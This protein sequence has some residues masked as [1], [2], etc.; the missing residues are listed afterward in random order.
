MERVETMILY[1]KELLNEAKDLFGKVKTNNEELATIITQCGI[2]QEVL[3]LIIN[4]NMTNITYSEYLLSLIK[5]HASIEWFKLIDVYRDNQIVLEEINDAFNDHVPVEVVKSYLAETEN[6]EEMM[7]KRYKWLKDNSKN[8]ESTDKATDKK[9]NVSR[10]IN[11]GSDSSENN[12]VDAVEKNESESSSFKKNET[13]MTISTSQ[14][15]AS[16]SDKP[17]ISKFIEAFLGVDINEDDHAASDDVL[18][19]EV[20]ANLTEINNTNKKRNLEILDLKKAAR[21]YQ[22][23]AA[24]AEIKNAELREEN[25]QLKNEL[26][27]VQKKLDAYMKRDELVSLQLSELNKIQKPN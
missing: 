11:S 16:E 27:E 5:K 20:L 13:S 8:E 1:E 17:A 10:E 21:M 2:E 14:E 9:N 6:P 19:Q 3:Q 4:N 24:S 7:D 22:A 12:A 26:A 18:F 23:N 15:A 25:Q